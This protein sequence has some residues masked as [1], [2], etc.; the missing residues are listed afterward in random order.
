[1]NI[2]ITGGLLGLAVVAILGAILL[3]MD[4]K[5]TAK[6]PK[7]NISGNITTAAL[8]PQQARI[9]KQPERVA[10]TP[11]IPATPVLSQSTDRLPTLKGRESQVNLEGLNGQMQE[12]TG[13]LRNLTQR[14]SELEQRL[15]HLSALL[16]HNQQRQ[17]YT[18]GQIHVSETDTQ[19][20]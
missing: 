17:A 10:T 13:E 7:D 12:I 4:E 1:V 14:T 16:E 11:P 5:H 18:S 9:S 3:G 20:R 19:T 8:P 6:E 15:D 2:L